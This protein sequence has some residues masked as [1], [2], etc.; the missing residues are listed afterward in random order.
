M[1]A[2]PAIERAKRMRARDG[3]R[4]LF[5]LRLAP[6]ALAA[7]IVAGLCAPSYLWLEPDAAAE[8]IGLG[9]LAAAGLATAAWIHGIARAGRAAVRSSRYLRNCQRAVESDAPVLMLAGIFQPR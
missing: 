5:A 9:C 6:A 2:G 4:L 1:I 8:H 7:A 3:A